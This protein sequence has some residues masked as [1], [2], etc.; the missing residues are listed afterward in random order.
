MLAQS[1]SNLQLQVQYVISCNYTSACVLHDLFYTGN[2]RKSMG[3]VLAWE[4]SFHFATL[5]LIYQRNDV[6][7]TSAE[8]PHWRRVTTQIW[9]VFLIGRAAW[10]ICF[11]QSEALPRSGWWRVIS[12]EFLRL[13]LRRHFAGKSVVASRNVSCFLRLVMFQSL[14]YF[15]LISLYFFPK[16]KITLCI[17]C[18]I[19]T[20]VGIVSVDIFPSRLKKFVCK[21]TLNSIRVM[22]RP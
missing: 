11:N 19:L 16:T 1:F 12:M 6:W 21:T 20:C 14:N 9:V 2:R 4:N 13:F 17:S 8:I 7:E 22:W 5:P 18:G 10:K 15:L 3:Y